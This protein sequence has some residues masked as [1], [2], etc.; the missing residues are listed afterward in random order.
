[1]ILTVAATGHRPDKLGGYGNPVAAARL[2]RVA[3]AFL[4]QLRPDR[5][6]SGMA[7]GWDTA[8]ARAA[9]AVGIPLVAAVPCGRNIQPSRWPEQARLEYHWILGRAAYVETIAAGPY[10]PEA[11][12]ARNEYMVDRCHLVAAM[13]N[14]S[15]G[16]TANCLDYA[17]GK[18][19]PVVNLWG[20]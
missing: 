6:I 8:F 15:A 12:Q 19:R 10:R 9:L 4:E 7:Q 20:I 1:M 11:M 16:G 18:G 3:I 13:W 2:E 14:G 17:R 5:A